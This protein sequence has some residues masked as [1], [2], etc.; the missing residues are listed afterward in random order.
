MVAGAAAEY[1][2]ISADSAAKEILSTY[3]NCGISEVEIADQVKIAA[4]GAGVAV[5]VGQRLGPR[6]TRRKVAS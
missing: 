6:A 2:A 5:K 3:P 4:A 1:G